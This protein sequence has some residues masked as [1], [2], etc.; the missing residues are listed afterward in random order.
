MCSSD[1]RRADV[2]EALIEG[3]GLKDLTWVAMRDDESLDR[4][5]EELDE[6]DP[7]LVLV[8]VRGVSVPIKSV[9]RLC[10]IAEKPMVKLPTGYSPAHVAS[11]I[12]SQAGD[13][14]RD[15]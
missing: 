10:T 13:E 4:L 6:I 14:L 11:Q 2:A 12:L 3:F 15:E 1:L 5:E 9:Q 7:A 8:G